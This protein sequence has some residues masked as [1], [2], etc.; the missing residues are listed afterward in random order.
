MPTL[1]LPALLFDIHFVIDLHVYLLH[2]YFP[3]LDGQVILNDSFEATPEGVISSFLACYPNYD[4][5]L[6]NLWKERYQVL[7]NNV[8]FD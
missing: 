3:L 1:H 6:E 8:F 2:G 4:S 5:G 7:V